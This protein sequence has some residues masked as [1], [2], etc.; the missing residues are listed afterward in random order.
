MNKN[1]L[2][3][4][5]IRT[6]FITPHLIAAGW[7]IHNQV[8]EEVSFTCFGTVYESILTELRDAGNKG[9]HYT[10]R[11]ITR[12]MTQMTAPKLGEK[13]LDPAAGTGGFLTAAIDHIRANEIRTLDDEA[14]LQQSI[15]GLPDLS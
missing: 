7:D 12:L 1:T 15:T 3:E 6:K 14:V 11:A 4:S 2:S 8:R 13:V 5:D 10:P 9:K